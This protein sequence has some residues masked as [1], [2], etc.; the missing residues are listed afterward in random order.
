MK[1]MIL[2]ATGIILSLASFAQFSFGLQGTGNLGNAKI[3]NENDFD[4]RKKMRAM[5]GA[6]IVVQYELGKHLAVRSGVNYQ[7][8]GVTL[9]TTVDESVNMKLEIQNSLRYVQLPVNLLYT[10]RLSRLQLYAGAGGY[11]NYGVDGKLKATLSFT[12]PDGSESK[13]TEKAKAFKKE[14]DGGAGFKKTDFGVGALAGIKLG[15]GLFANVG[16][17]LSLSNINGTDDDA[18]YKNRGIQL[19]I[20]YFF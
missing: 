17:Q 20:G 2:S 1:K 12:M 7:Q 16:Y 3:K 5:P 14:E 4:Y 11:I 18:V 9:K 19:T 13:V 15:K 6:G 10:I 8:N